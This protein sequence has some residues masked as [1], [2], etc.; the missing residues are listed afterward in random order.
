MA[1]IFVSVLFDMMSMGIVG[2]VLPRLIKQF[3]GSSERAGVYSGVLI[4]I[5]ALA[6]TIASPVIGALSDQFGRRPIILFSTAGLAVDYL[7]MAL[8]PNLGWLAAGRVIAGLTSATVATASAYTTD[9]TSPENRA[10]TYGLIGA[11]F[12]TGLIA[13]P[14]LGG[15][16]GEW[17]LRTP[18][19]VSAA[20]S[21][22]A[23]LY[24]LF[25]LPE[26]LPAG[27]RMTFSWKRANPLGALNLLRSHRELLGLAGLLWLTY[28]A[29]LAFST[30]F[31]LYGIFRYAWGTWES[32]MLLAVFGGLGVIVQALLVGPVT[33]KLGER[34]T[35][36][37]G[38]L[39]NALG[40]AG[41]GLA[42]N[43]AFFFLAL[44][45]FALGGLATPA[46]QALMTRQVSSNQQGQ[47]QGAAACITSIASLVAPPLFGLI[48]ALSLKGVT[49]NHR[50]SGAAFLVAALLQ[51]MAKFGTLAISQRRNT[52]R[53]RSA[54][55]S[56][57]TTA[58]SPL[59]ARGEIE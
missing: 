23:F 55:T 5:W 44:G 45:A 50:L 35:L 52:D 19:W 34:A 43:G 53:Q 1:F 22:C 21:L 33:R 59:G 38:L 13:G 42:E 15:I 20:L 25:V 48:Y 29:N 26:S 28:S 12:A 47:L 41:M 10:S 17:E 36:L 14:L 39:M 49:Q 54:K 46:L 8:A 32:G 16:A 24:G 57:P 40:F 37:L 30:I 51:R 6:Q 18:F 9:I 11:A 3:A 27:R 56:V 2:P 58:T 31:V 7:I 4:S